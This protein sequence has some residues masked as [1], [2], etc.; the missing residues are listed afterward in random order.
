M[1]TPNKITVEAGTVAWCSCFKSKNF[2]YCD[3]SHQ[4]TDK[5]PIIE[6]IKE[7]TDKYICQCGK[8][9]NAPFCNGAHKQTNKTEPND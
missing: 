1:D 5:L 8:T 4:G 2:P 3:G 7:P 6:E 9:T